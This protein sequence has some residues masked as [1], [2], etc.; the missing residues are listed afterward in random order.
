MI[1]IWLTSNYLTDLH[2]VSLFVNDFANKVT[3]ISGYCVILSGLIFTYFFPVNRTSKTIEFI[4]L[5]VIST[6]ALIA[7]STN[8]IAG[9]VRLVNEKL[10]F[11]V[12]QFLWLY[13]LVVLVLFSLIARNLLLLPKGSGKESRSQAKLV[14]SAFIIGAS[15]GLYLML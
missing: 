4:G 7:S 8:L 15:V 11:S 13:L 6:V 5:S 2:G 12:G 3:Y 1:S 10:S 14:L 9:N